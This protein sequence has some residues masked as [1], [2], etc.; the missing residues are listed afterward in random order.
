MYACIFCFMHIQ[1]QILV[2]GSSFGKSMSTRGMQ[3]I[4]RTCNAC[5]RHFTVQWLF[6]LASYN[7][8]LAWFLEKGTSWFSD[9]VLFKCPFVTSKV[10]NIIK[11]KVLDNEYL[12]GLCFFFSSHQH[13]RNMELCPYSV[14]TNFNYCACQRYAKIYNCGFKNFNFFEK[15][16][17]IKK[18]NLK[19]QLLK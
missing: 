3:N 15:N 13:L 17:K 18:Q 14:L 8:L 16:L 11:F 6:W 4:Q 9:H 12:L 5:E 1:W 2:T 7:N 10:I 19:V